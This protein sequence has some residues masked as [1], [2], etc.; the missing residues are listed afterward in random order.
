MSTY[1]SAGV[2]SIEKDISELIPSLA[3]STAALVGWSAKGN[4]DDI[5][6]ITNKQQFIDEYGKPDNT[7]GNYFHYTALAF[8]EQ[9]NKLWCYRVQENAQYGGYAIATTGRTNETFSDLSNDIDQILDS[10]YSGNLTSEDCLFMIMGKDPGVW[11]TRISVAIDKLISSDR[12][13]DVG[14]SPSP[15]IADSLVPADVDQYTFRIK[16]YWE[17]DDGDDELVETWI[18]S[19]KH[20]I[21]GYGKQLYLEDKING[22]SNYIYVQDNTDIDDTEMPDG[23]ATQVNFG[24]GSDGTAYSSAEFASAIASGWDKFENPADVDIRI[25][26][27][28][29]ETNDTV[30]TKMKEI[31][32]SRADCIAIL[33]IDYTQM[34]LGVDYAVTWRK[35]TININSNY[36]ALYAPWVRINDPYNDVLIYVPPSGYV[37]A[38]FAYNDYVAQPWNAPAGFNR[39]MLNILSMQDIFTEG[40]RDT[41][42]EAQINPL[43]TFRGEGD[44]IWGQKTLTSKTSALSRV[45]VRRMLIVIEKAMAISLRPFV[46]EN[47][48]Q[49]TRFKINAMLV[50]Y[51]DLIS[52]QGAFQTESGDKGYKVIVDETNNTPAIIDRNE[53]H[54]D[55]FVKPARTAEFIQLQT[56]VTRTGASFNELIVQGV[57]L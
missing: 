5:R 32:E 2:Y 55:V 9:G 27:N 48:S 53:L 43:Q 44:V 54:V 6:L 15:D 46:F 57:N 25:L 33:D 19:R 41:L 42:Y 34:G 18:V 31:A 1:L 28:G 22:Y 35:D 16:V 49:L 3:T 4:V 7:T 52:S 21:D 40:E 37:G 47:N 56:V 10:G 39:G 12:S 51:L 45:N 29:G 23:F 24:S 50:E 17:N 8:L 30:Q 38:Q 26:L 11:N 36:C 20:K 14:S 13:W